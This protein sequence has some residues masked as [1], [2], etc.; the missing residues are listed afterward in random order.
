MLTRIRCALA[1][2]AMVGSLIASHPA[3]A[4]TKDLQIPDSAEPAT[5][6]RN[7]DGDTIMVDIDERLGTRE[8]TVRMIGIDTPETNYSYGNEPECFGKEATNKTDSLLITAKHDT[9]WLESD[10]SDTDAYDRLLRYVWYESTIDGKVH[11]LNADLVREGYAL[12]KHYEPNTARQ[13]T[14]DDA[15]DGAISNAAGMWLTCD[16]PVS[17]DPTLEA[18]GKPDDAPIDRTT[19]PVSADDEAVC[20]FFDSQQDAQDMMDVYPE[21]E[22]DLDPDGNSIACDNYFS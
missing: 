6:V 11:F 10:T 19:T 14:L 8:Y 9:L 15:Q 1:L 16:E 2:I 22:P 3:T 12:S 18:D 20:S 21:F 7:I 17:M 5:Y 4:K 13:S